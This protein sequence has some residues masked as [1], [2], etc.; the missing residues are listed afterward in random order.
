M[1]LRAVALR[2]TSAA[3]LTLDELACGERG[4]WFREH[5]EPV[6]NVTPRSI[7]GTSFRTFSQAPN[8]PSRSRQRRKS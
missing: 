8:I 6:A 5:A 4:P 3:C 2:S 7:G 1:L